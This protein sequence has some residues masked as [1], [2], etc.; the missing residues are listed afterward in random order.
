[1]YGG[2]KDLIPSTLLELAWPYY[3][4]ASKIKAA[5]LHAEKDK[6]GKSLNAKKSGSAAAVVLSKKILVTYPDGSKHLFN[7]LN[8]ADCA[9]NVSHG[10][11]FKSIKRGKKG[12]KSKLAGYQFELAEAM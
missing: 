8:D 7:S 1:M 9:L 10:A 6:D 12:N 2:Q 4:E 5:K 11:V 3:C